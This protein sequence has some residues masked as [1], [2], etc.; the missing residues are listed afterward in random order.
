MPLLFWNYAEQCVDDD[1]FK[2]IYE[3]MT[4]GLKVDNY[5]L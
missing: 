1:D 4:H 3:N 2:E 5:Q